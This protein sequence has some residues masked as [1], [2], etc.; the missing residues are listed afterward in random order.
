MKNKSLKTFA[1]RLFT[2]SKTSVSGNAPI[3]GY[4][5]DA[6]LALTVGNTAYEPLPKESSR[7]ETPVVVITGFSIHKS[8]DSGEE[9]KQA[10]EDSLDEFHICLGLLES[11]DYDENRGGLERLIYKVNTELVNSAKINESMAHVL[12]CGGPQSDDN[13]RLRAAFLSFFC[14][15]ENGALSPTDFVGI[16]ANFDTYYRHNDIDERSMDSDFDQ[17]AGKHNGALRLPALRVLASS[18]ELLAS[19]KG[20]G[21]KLDIES[22]FWRLVLTSLSNMVEN[23]E[24]RR[25]DA[26]LSIRCLRLLCQVETPLI[27]SLVRYS[28]FPCILHAKDVGN[29]TRYRMLVKEVDA[30]LGPMGLLHQSF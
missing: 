27:S 16:E 23:V 8:N 13:R 12:A 11:G 28:L 20:E 9:K 25:M 10:D 21:Q 30:L 1:A 7:S 5:K 14:F 24:A 18:L 29:Q 2:R 26:A 6:P 3:A 15:E 4:T 22:T 17:P 19:S